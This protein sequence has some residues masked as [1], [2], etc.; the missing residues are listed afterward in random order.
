MGPW[1]FLLRCNTYSESILLSGH[2][3]RLIR[4]SEGAML[5]SKIRRQAIADGKDDVWEEL[6]GYIRAASTG[7]AACCTGSV[8]ALPVDEALLLQNN[9]EMEEAQHMPLPEED[10]TDFSNI[11]L[12]DG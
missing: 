4:H 2:V 6:T 10:D 7:T 1:G 9:G 3:S 12:E 11:L 5:T 8:T